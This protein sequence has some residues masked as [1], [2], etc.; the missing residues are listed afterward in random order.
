LSLLG[1]LRSIFRR[2]QK[3]A[4]YEGGR[5]TKANRD[6]W[7]ANSPFET[8]AA[9]DRDILRARARWLHENNPIM[10][11]IDKTIVNNVVGRGIT[12]QSKTGTK[13]A[14]EEIERL[15]REWEKR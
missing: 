7:N 9:P 10:A 4:F 2:P 6:F 14:D 3:R 12:L 1:R 5:I 11:N 8:T 13:R 15:W